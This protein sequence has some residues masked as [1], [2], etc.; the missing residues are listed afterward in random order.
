MARRYKKVIPKGKGERLAK[1]KR[2]KHKPDKKY[3]GETSQE[4]ERRVAE[5]REEER[6]LLANAAAVRRRGAEEARR[7]KKAGLPPPAVS[8]HAPVKP[9]VN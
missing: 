4:E 8:F 9:C 6:N 2:K 7:R 3:K 5:L 1:N